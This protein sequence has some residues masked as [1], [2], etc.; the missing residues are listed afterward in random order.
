ML[1]ESDLLNLILLSPLDAIE[2]I[3]K[4]RV[5]YGDVHPKNASFIGD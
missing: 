3:H 2:V 4:V 1:E 5:P